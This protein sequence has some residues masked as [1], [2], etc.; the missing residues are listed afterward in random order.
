[1]RSGLLLLLVTACG[2]RAPTVDDP[3]S[4]PREGPGPVES[5]AYSVSIDAELTEL[6]VTVCYDG[7]HGAGLR[8]PQPTAAVALRSAE[9]RVPGQ[10]PRPVS[11]RDRI[12][13]VPA[14]LPEDGCMRYVVNIDDA[15]GASWSNGTRVQDAVLINL[16]GWLWAPTPLAPDASGSLAVELP[17]GVEAAFAFPRERDGGYRL[18]NSAFRYLSHTVFGRFDRFDVPVP[19]GHLDVARLPGELAV[20]DEQLQ[21]WLATAGRTAAQLDGE[22]PVQHAMV[23]LVPVAGDKNVAFGNVGRGGGSSV[24]LLTSRGASYR[25]LLDDW[26]PPHEFTHLSMPFVH[27]DDAWMSEGVATYYQEVL[28]ARAGLQTPLDAWRALDHGFATGREDGTGRPL[29]VESAQMFRT[30]AF[31]RVYWAGTAIALLSDVEMRKAGHSLDEA[32][33]GLPDCC[34]VPMRSWTGP[35]MA[36]AFDEITST[37][38]SEEVS[39]RWL[40]RSEFPE[41]DDVYAWLGLTRNDEGLLELAEDAPGIAIRDAIMSPK[42]AEGD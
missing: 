22:F 18:E 9:V 20:T 23:A 42:I 41:V 17:E 14:G 26:V 37:H 12:I 7:P 8:C 5:Y 35:E 40:P 11:R 2:T 39:A 6:Q 24:M 32:I 33:E 19:G 10:A 31:R 38:A 13:P 15:M 25:G 30:Q 4:S 36:R 1:M 3:R 34:M 29:E 27:R 16:S 21:S 28:R